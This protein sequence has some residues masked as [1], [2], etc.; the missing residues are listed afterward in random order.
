MQQRMQLTRIQSG[1]PRRRKFDLEAWFPASQCYRE[2]VSCSNCLDYQ[3]RNL[4]IKFQ[5]QKSAF[6]PCR[7]QKQLFQKHV[8]LSLV[9]VIISFIFHFFTQC[10]QSVT[11]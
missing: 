2:L 9:F 10:S 7:M 6:S 11:L 3:S 8:L 4:D 1:Y 5:A